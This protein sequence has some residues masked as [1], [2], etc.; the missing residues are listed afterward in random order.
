LRYDK[1]SADY[2]MDIG[3]IG[4]GGG[5]GVDSAW[6]MLAGS[7]EHGDEPSGSVATELVR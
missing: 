2:K 5:G 3:E 7:C 6:G 1:T 4:W